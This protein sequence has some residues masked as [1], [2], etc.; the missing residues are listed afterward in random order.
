[1]KNISI[2]YKLNVITYLIISVL[3]IFSFSDTYSQKTESRF[4][5]ARVKYS[6]GGDWYNDQTSEPN[7]LHFIAQNTNLQVD[8]IYQSVDLASD[9]LFEYPV[10]FLTGHG[11]VDFS[12]EEVRNLKAY[13]ENGGFLY[14]DDDYGLDKFIRN[15]MKKIFPDQDFVDL[16]LSHGIYSCQFKFPDGCPKIHKHDGLPPEGL[17]LFYNGRLCVYY[18]YQSNLGDG[19]AD[20]DIYH[21]PEAKRLASLKMGTNIVVWALTH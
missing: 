15:Q 5:L 7:L 18:T 16:P 12:P 17:G 10:L 9:N 8:S 13:L 3:L 14:I 1:M 6:G 19:W 20:A 4:K 2:K 11:D 21:D